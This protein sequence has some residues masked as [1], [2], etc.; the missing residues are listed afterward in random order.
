MHES[1]AQELSLVCCAD[2]GY[3]M[4]L[5]VTL[6]SAAANLTRDCNPIFYLL[7]AGISFGN[8]RRIEQVVRRGHPRAL[9]NWIIVDAKLLEGLP[10]IQHLN[11]VTYM[12]L[13]VPDVLPQSVE[14]VIYLDCDLIVQNDLS[15]IWQTSLDGHLVLAVRDFGVPTL[16]SFKGIRTHLKRLGLTADA[17]YFNAG[18]MML[19]LVKWREQKVS[20]RVIEFTRENEGTN[21]FCDQDGLNGVIGRNWKMLPLQWNSQIG[22]LRHL[23]QIEDCPLRTELYT[24]QQNLLKDAAI[25]HFTG[26]GKPWNSGLRSPARPIFWSYLRRSGWFGPAGYHAFRLASD[27]TAARWYAK[28]RFE[29]WQYYRNVALAEKATAK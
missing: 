6:F 19:D 28:T 18:V 1:G 7:D 4:P 8:K 10:L 5:A 15:E 12:R 13:L 14:K 22:A 16:G 24:S 26:G 9:V 29:S 23:D 27:V 17:P 20:R 21:N 11:L 2:D 3:A 25:L